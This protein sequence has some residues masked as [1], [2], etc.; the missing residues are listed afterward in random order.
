M[1]GNVAFSS[2]KRQR[3]NRNPSKMVV[4]QNNNFI[5]YNFFSCDLNSIKSDF[6]YLVFVYI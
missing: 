3:K 5:Y 2:W 1:L 4:L 6:Q